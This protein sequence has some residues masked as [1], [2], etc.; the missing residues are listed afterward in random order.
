M[1]A[2]KNGAAHALL[3][4]SAVTHTSMV[5]S[6]GLRS[7]QFAPAVWNGQ[8][9]GMMLE[10]RRVLANLCR[11]QRDLARILAANARCASLGKGR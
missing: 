2:P 6:C 3:L 1:D 4:R 5:G 8:S 9:A 10:D 11:V 7:G